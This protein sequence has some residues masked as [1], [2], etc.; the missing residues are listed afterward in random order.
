MKRIVL[1]H[2]HADHRGTAPCMGAPVYCHPTRSPTPKATPR[3]T[4]TWTSPSCRALRARLALPAAAAALGRRRGEDRRHRL[5][6]RRGRRLRGRPLPRPRAG[7]DRPLARERP[8]GAGQRR[9]LPDR[10]GAA[11]QTAA[12]RARRASPIPA[13][14]WDHAKA[15]ESV[16][17]L[18]AL[19]PAV[20]GAGH[21]EPLRGDNL[22]ETLERAAEKY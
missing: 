8:R 16:R 19:D 18:A 21:A 10:L 3:S 9:R 5:R 22:R 12:A 14:A 1:G 4:P 17:K 2:A 6:G 11:G 7:A 15:K 13:W 20:V